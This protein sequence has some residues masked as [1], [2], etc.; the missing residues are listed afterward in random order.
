M[1]LATEFLQVS[2]WK[3]KLTAMIS[4]VVAPKVESL[5]RKEGGASG[6]EK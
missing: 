6:E 1:D 5:A 4:N 3:A 2:I